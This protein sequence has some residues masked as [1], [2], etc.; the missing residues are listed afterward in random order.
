MGLD[1]VWF[2]LALVKEGNR[3][4]QS[5]KEDT[6]DSLKNLGIFNKVPTQLSSTT[7]TLTLDCYCF[8]LKGYEVW[9]GG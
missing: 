1:G 4:G 9:H 8:A 5:L 6:S 2:T 3:S 7:L